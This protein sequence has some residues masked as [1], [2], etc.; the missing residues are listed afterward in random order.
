MKSYLDNERAENAAIL[1]LLELIND[2]DIS[3]ETAI[4]H[5]E[6]FNIKEKFMKDYEISQRY[7]IKN[8][9]E[10][11]GAMDVLASLI[12]KGKLTMEIAEEHAKFIGIDNFA[13]KVKN[14]V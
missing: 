11:Q 14:M 5:A 10:E 6:K 12:R 8:N 7:K 13:E 3:L 2:N 9:L 1:T 4:R